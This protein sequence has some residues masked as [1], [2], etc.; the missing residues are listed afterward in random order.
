MSL[1][2]GFVLR[3]GLV[4]RVFERSHHCPIAGR[5]FAGLQTPG[6]VEFEVQE[7]FV[8]R[9]QIVRSPRTRFSVAVMKPS[10]TKRFDGARRTVS[11][12]V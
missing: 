2:T 9:V 6:V 12:T 1:S 7:V 10:S 4:Q 3:Q 11:P 8:R 5:N